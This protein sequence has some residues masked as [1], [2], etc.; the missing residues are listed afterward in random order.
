[1]VCSKT[2]DVARSD[3]TRNWGT[4]VVFQTLAK[5][6]IKL[7]FR[8][9]WEPC[10]GLFVCSQRGQACLRKKG[11]LEAGLGQLVGGGGGDGPSLCVSS[12]L[13][14]PQAWLAG[15]QAGA[16][17]LS[18]VAAGRAWLYLLGLG[19]EEQQQAWVLV[20]SQGLV[21]VPCLH[22]R[23]PPP[24]SNLCSVCMEIRVGFKAK[25]QEDFLLLEM[26]PG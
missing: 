8:R 7:A 9:G 22:K 16:C 17:G 13:L 5:F 4:L 14:A 21:S 10:A 23:S 19:Q 2:T 11:K 18:G 25:N 24:K 6:A 12:S 15:A 26:E 3:V 1:M 20:C